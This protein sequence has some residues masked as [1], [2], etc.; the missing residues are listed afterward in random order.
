MATARWF[1][2]SRSDTSSDRP[3][4]D[5]GE[6]NVLSALVDRLRP[7]E[8]WISLPLVMVLAGVM[9]WS[10]SDA[11]WILG[12]DE[13]TAFLI[14]VALGGAFWGYLSA[15]LEMSAW[16]AHSLGA[17]VGAFVLIEVVGS[18]L[19]GATPGLGG[20]FNA[21]ANSIA[22]AY[23]DLTWRHQLSTLQVGHF[24]LLL[25]VIVWGT[26]QAAA[27][28]VFGHHRAV[29]GVLLMA[30]L[31][32]ANMA[33]TVQDQFF[34]LVI[35]SAAALVL[36]LVSHAADERTSWL[37]H[38]IWRGRD[39][40][41]PQL[42][43]GVAFASIAVAMSL[44]LASVASSAPLASA[45]PGLSNN[46][47][48]VS[49]W[50][51]GYLPNGGVTR[52][53]PGADF[54]LTS[55][56]SSSFHEGPN[57]AFTVRV[58]TGSEAYHWRL[59]TYDAFQTNGWTVSPATR[60]DQIPAGGSLN[61]GTSDQVGPTSPGRKLVTFVVHIQDP[62]LRHVVVANEPASVN[63]AVRRS[64]VGADSGQANVA[65]FTTDA[66][67]YSVSAYVPVLDPGGTGLTEWRLRHA[68]TA[69]PQAVLKRYTQGVDLV[70]ADGKSLLNEIAAD[71]RAQGIPFDNEF[72]VAKEMQDYLHSSSNFT[73]S[74]DISS[75][76]PQCTGLSTVDCFAFIREGFCEQYAT[77][78]TMLMRMKGYPARY[79]LGYLPGAIDPHSLVQ[80]VTSQQKHAWVEVFFPS[81]GWVPFDPTGGSV[82][83]E[84]ILAP[85]SAVAAT[86][87][88]SLSSAPAGSDG[89][90]R[91]HRSAPPV[92]ATTAA[93]TGSGAPLVVL[94]PFAIGA[95]LVIML[96][97][98]WRRRPRRL[99]SPDAVYRS[100]VRLASR[101]GY[102]PEP[103]Q[104]VYEY[105]GMLADL[106]PG[107]RDSL[108][109]VATAAV[110]VTYGRRQLGSDRLL[111]LAAASGRVRQALLRLVFRLPGL[112]RRR[113]R[114]G[115]S[116]RPKTR[117]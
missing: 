75:E 52:Y 72:D 54:G 44:L 97:V 50:L 7:D 100:M 79:V 67:D 34:G 83:L 77:T 104:T 116:A 45:W 109:V 18:I 107:A 21:T 2:P 95:V 110:E 51:S 80:Q 78:M 92:G 108:G 48:D 96:F 12:R 86:P 17:A 64:V 74:T 28:D 32:I 57:N 30:V 66:Q 40:Q 99:E 89:P 13:M 62:S 73:Y 117:G 112:G 87:S 90:D 61:A 111:A 98:M 102:R 5:S 84:T 31:L 59:V 23:L 103:T 9:A 47:R 82:G 56:I 91:L 33:L 94:L 42:R 46:F 29:N 1:P 69:F 58:S 49:D 65:W 68:G 63:V 93:P 88:A 16:L 37:R 71:A 20:W 115:N 11:R 55:P 105:T 25:G 39:F 6:S 85:G 3:S 10:I 60:Q 15:R 41:A 4:I 8:G 14:Y 35:F 38:Q 106:V 101:L 114:A 76:M 43:G 113:G 24:C 26:A 53:Q 36:L 81:Y 70:G 27:Y 22:Q 19:P